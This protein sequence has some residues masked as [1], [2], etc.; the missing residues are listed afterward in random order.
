MLSKAQLAISFTI[1]ASMPLHAETTNIN[2]LLQD[3]IDHYPAIKTAYFEVAKAQQESLKIQGQ[4]GW[5]LGAETGLAKE[6]SFLGQPVEQLSLAGNLRRKLESGDSLSFSARLSHEDADAVLTGFPNP[7]TSSDLKLE[8]DM[9]LGK[10]AGNIRYTT[11]LSQAKAG[12]DIKVAE[13]RILLDKM[14]D[15]V[16]ELY[17]ASLNTKQ[18]IENTQASIKRTKKLSRFINDRLKLGIVEDKDQ[19]QTDAQLQSQIAQLTSLQLAWTQQLISMNR[20][21]GKKWD[22]PLSL[23]IPKTNDHAA[24]TVEHLI[25]TVKAHSP[26]LSQIDSLIFISDEQIKL[27]RQN[28]KNEIGLKFF[29]GNKTSE[30]DTPPDSSI[31]N[32]DVVAGV[33]LAYSQALNKSADN[34]ALYQ[35]QL[36]RGLQLQNKKQ[37]LENLHYDLASNLAESA[38]I[39]HSIQAYKNSKKAEQKKLKDAEQ[40]YKSGRIDIDQLLQFENQLSATDL[41]LNIQ[42]LAL[43]Q[44][45]LKLSLLTGSIW[46]EIKLPLYDFENDNSFIEEAL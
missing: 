13:Q 12:V 5:Q 33:N 20:L 25:E 39:K 8:Y 19:L 3:V 28:R 26:A 16:I 4:L 17:L 22:Q 2:H 6:V 9:P 42:K 41:A 30:G 23:H 36:N 18:R 14:A 29:I 37:L 24:A 34:A 27:Q 45:L 43:Q 38:A 10:A 46:K 11:S 7:S 31:S 32:S 35:A 1:C 40:R 21:T 15:Q 44:R